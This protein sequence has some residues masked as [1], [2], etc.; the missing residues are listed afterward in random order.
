MANNL[1][2][3]GEVIDLYNANNIARM[4][5]NDPD[6]ATM[7]ALRNSNIELVIGVPNEN[8]ES[9]ANSV[10]SANYWVQNNI[11]KYSHDIKS[12]Y[13]VVWNEIDPNIDPKSKFVLPAMQNIK[14]A[15]RLVEI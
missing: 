5:I 6:Q 4:R 13:I 12:R 15:L 10:S 1:P 2:S 14:L 8:I 9:I 7:E 11:L 3:V